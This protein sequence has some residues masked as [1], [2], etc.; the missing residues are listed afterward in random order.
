MK[1]LEK[2]AERWYLSNFRVDR[3]QKVVEE[4]EVKLD[5]LRPPPHDSNVS[6]SSD[7]QSVIHLM[8]LQ[9]DQVEQRITGG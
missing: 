6:N 7:N 4:K 5:S 8:E 2:E 1:Q 3:H 9:R